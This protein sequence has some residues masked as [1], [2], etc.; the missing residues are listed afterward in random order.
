MRKV[1]VIGIGETPFKP[2]HP[3]MT[4]FEL[5]YEAVKLAVRDAGISRDDIQSVV[6]GI[7]NELFQRQFIPEH[8]LGDYIGM[9][10]RPGT[11][12]A[13]GGATGGYALRAGYMEIA[14]GLSDVAMVLGVEKCLDCF[15][16]NTG[17]ATPEVLKAISYSGDMTWETPLGLIP[18]TTYA[19]V[20]RAHMERYGGPTEE[21]MAKV[22]VKNHKHAI[23]NPIAQSPME[24]TVEEVLASRMIVY[25]FKMLDCCQYSEGAAAMILASEEKARELG[26]NPLVWI[27]GVGA[28]NDGAFVGKGSMETIGHIMSDHLAARQAY[29]MAGI[30]NPLKELDVAEIHDAFTGQEIMTYE[31]LMFC[32]R[33]QGGRLIDEGVVTMEGEL[34]TCTSGGLIG[35]GHAVG[36]TAVM[37]GNEVVR[38]LRG[39][40]HNPVKNA[41]RGLMHSTG[42]ALSAYGVVTIFERDEA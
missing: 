40:S 32:E 38:Q 5:G 30:T 24:L 18:A 15:D 8:F 16:Y 27:T 39:T 4:Y 10:G 20:V 42:G 12:V 3:E 28:A 1:A 9:L 22:S 7:Y 23:G 31:E 35:C 19:N 21:Q 29:K 14:S 33:G 2:R 26:K 34:P 17:H 41:R 6:Y 25:P 13:N 37:Q 11:R 36:G